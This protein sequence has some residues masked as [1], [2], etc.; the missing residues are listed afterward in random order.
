MSAVRS[1]PTAHTSLAYTQGSQLPI[2]GAEG[3]GRPSCVFISSRLVA[4]ILHVTTPHCISASGLQIDCFNRA[5]TTILA[6]IIPHSTCLTAH[7]K[8][9]S[10]DTAYSCMTNAKQEEAHFHLFCNMLSL[11]HGVSFSHI[12]TKSL[13]MTECSQINARFAPCTCTIQNVPMTNASI[14]YKRTFNTCPLVGRW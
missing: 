7:E 4:C 9:P 1:F 5:N 11:N 12:A 10:K 8:S 2:A 3:R 13:C 6:S 14:E